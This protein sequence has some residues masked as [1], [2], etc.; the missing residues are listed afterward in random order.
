VDAIDFAGDVRADQPRRDRRR[1]L[2]EALA[3]YSEQFD[4]E[5]LHRELLDGGSL[6]AA[7]LGAGEDRSSSSR[8]W[9]PTRPL[10][11]FIAKRG[12]GLHHIAYEVDD[13]EARSTLRAARGE[14]DRQGR[15]APAS[16]A[17]ASPS[18]TRAAASA[19]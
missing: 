5:L 6:D 4:V 17:R 14:A 15:R 19:C 11:R 13:I 9:S 7:L 2:D 3:L 18:S 12:P 1:E 10:G 16:T 8:R